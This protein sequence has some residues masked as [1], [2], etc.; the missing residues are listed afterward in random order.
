[1]I[2]PNWPEVPATPAPDP[3]NPAHYRAGGFEV[4]DIIEAFGLNWRMANVV[5]YAL[6]AGRKG[7]RL[8]DLKKCLWYV[9][10]E[11]DRCGEGR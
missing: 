8:E 10:R 9:Q 1:V 11:I 7:D 6:R 4:A 5:K 2:D 3:I